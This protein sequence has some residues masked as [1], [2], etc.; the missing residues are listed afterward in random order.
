M[1]APSRLDAAQLK[2]VMVEYHD[3][4]VLHRRRLNQLNVY[5]VPDA[6]TGTNMSMTMQSVV[7]ALHD[8][9]DAAAIGAAIA[10]G[11]L[12]G[13]RGASGVIL[14]QLLGALA[15][16]LGGPEPVDGP[17]F[18]VALDEAARA[19]YSAVLSPVEGTILTVVRAAADAA[20]D[21]A[22]VS[23]LGAI[24]AARDG[25]VAALE[26]T[27]DL[28]PE[29]AAAGVVDAGGAGFVL[30]F[31]ALLHVLAGA[32]VPA[33]EPEGARPV[34]V[35]APPQH[36][37]YEVVV[38]L[39]ADAGGIPDFRSAWA[40]L[41]N[42]STVI[43]EGEGRWVA[44]VHTDAPRAAMDAAQAVGRILEVQVTDLIAQVTELT[45]HAGGV[46]GTA[47]VVVTEGDG[48]RELF[49]R[50]GAAA[51]V[52]GGP[53]RKPSTAE[54]LDA[55][56]RTGS[57]RVIILPNDPR[58]QPAAAQVAGLTQTNVAV[59]PTTTMVEGMT[60]LA[61][62][63]QTRDTA[64]NLAAM[65]AAV[66]NIRSG[67]VTQAVADA[68]SERGPIHRGDWLG[69]SGDGL[70]VVAATAGEAANSLLAELADGDVEA[71]IIVAGA[72]ADPG[73]LAG[74]QGMVDEH[75]PGMEIQV[76]SGGQ[77][78]YPYLLGVEIQRSGR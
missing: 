60:A 54:L 27:P 43:V 29:L 20:A 30:W 42:D 21:A 55:V 61:A 7:D 38:H 25:A 56:E 51:I 53:A 4:L 9:E 77:P 6:D 31:D 1:S 32:P 78:L 3:V 68:D 24:V 17:G 71:V 45:A 69:M 48:L 49:R 73:V 10:K 22:D 64:A 16:R 63:D 65:A 47:L 66:G 39:A 40:E 5:P 58:V 41:G 46:S 11:A 18:A 12:L 59:A 44:H 62:F 14:S 70:A 74:I 75:W 34:A 13:A 8:A 57:S 52:A 26:R 36:P 67:S 35:S 2:R 23:L 15:N 33:P 19:G 72:E 76:I 50:G 37:R 28:L